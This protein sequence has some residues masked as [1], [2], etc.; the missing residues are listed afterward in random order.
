MDTAIKIPLR[1]LSPGMVQDLQEKYPEAMVHVEFSNKAIREGLSEE[2]FWELIALLD[3]SKAGDDTAIIEPMVNSLA[4]SPIRHIYEFED[5]LSEKLYNLDRL[6]FARNTGAS[7]YQSDDAF[8]SVD[9]FLYDRCSVVA[10]GKS[11][12]EQVL[13]APEKMPK[14]KSFG[15]LLRVASLAYKRKTGKEFEYVPAFNY[16]TYANK[17][18]WKNAG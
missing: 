17:E 5:L 10:N 2:R 13:K 15:A 8:F 3:W 9:G 6:D 1:S 4:V 11:F 16:E 12:Y 18:G 7:A 14:D